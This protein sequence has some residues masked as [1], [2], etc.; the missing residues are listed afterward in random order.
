M[1]KRLIFTVAAIIALSFAACK[2][3]RVCECTSNGNTDKVTINDATKRQG[4]ANCVST[5]TDIGNGVSVKEEC[6]LK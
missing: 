2:K 4:K 3:D 6:E 5:T 1:K